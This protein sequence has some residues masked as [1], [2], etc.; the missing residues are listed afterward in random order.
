MQPQYV[1]ARAPAIVGDANAQ[2]VLSTV[3]HT[4]SEQY[5]LPEIFQASVN[6]LLAKPLLPYNPYPQILQDIGFTAFWS[7]RSWRHAARVFTNAFGIS[8][9][10]FIYS[11]LHSLFY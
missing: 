1:V 8:P 3:V 6:R 9:W 7:E 4:L 2:R 11:S 5:H 10:V